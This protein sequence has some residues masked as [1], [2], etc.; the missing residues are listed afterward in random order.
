MSRSRTANHRRATDVGMRKFVPEQHPSEPQLTAISHA[1]GAAPPNVAVGI[2]DSWLHKLDGRH[3]IAAN[4]V[5]DLLLDVR[6][7]VG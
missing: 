7:A 1:V 2:I 6:N 5:R 3:S 4:E